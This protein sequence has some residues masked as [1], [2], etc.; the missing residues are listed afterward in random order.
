MAGQVWRPNSGHAVFRHPAEIREAVYTINA[1][2]SFNMSL[3]PK[4]K[5]QPN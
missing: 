4:E 2:K 1:I 3:R 5:N